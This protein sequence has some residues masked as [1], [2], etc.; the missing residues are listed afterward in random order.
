MT[1]SSPTAV[2]AKHLKKD[3]LPNTQA[4]DGITFFQFSKFERNVIMALTGEGLELRAGKKARLLDGS[5]YGKVVSLRNT[6]R[7]RRY[8]EMMQ[9]LAAERQDRYGASQGKRCAE[10]RQAE[11]LE[12]TR[13]IKATRQ[14]YIEFLAISRKGSFSAKG[15]AR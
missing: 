7:N 5:A 9:R 14:K 10:A 1:L 8:H 13:Q 2:S 12:A 15:A 11:E 3:W 4:V 6:E